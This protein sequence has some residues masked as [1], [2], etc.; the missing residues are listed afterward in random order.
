MWGF[1]C[2]STSLVEEHAHPIVLFSSRGYLMIL[3]EVIGLIVLFVVIPFA[4]FALVRTDLAWQM[5][6]VLSWP[7]RRPIEKLVEVVM[8]T[9]WYVHDE[10]VL[11]APERR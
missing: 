7:I 1:G 4:F 9:L 6:Y 8:D 11:E 10:L 2:Y 5:C 3:S